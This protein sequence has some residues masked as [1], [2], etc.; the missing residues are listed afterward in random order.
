MQP[1]KGNRQPEPPQQL[2]GLD[3]ALSPVTHLDHW[4]HLQL[5]PP[6]VHLHAPGL[7]L[8]TGLNCHT[9]MARASSHGIA[10]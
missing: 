1:Q 4:A 10:R 8:N 5:T 9:P 7:S 6:A 3:L 2:V